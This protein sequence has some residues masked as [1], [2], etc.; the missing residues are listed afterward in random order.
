[1]RFSWALQVYGV[2][3]FVYIVTMATLAISKKIAAAGR[4]L[5]DKHGVEGVTMRRVAQAV[6]VTPMAIYRHYA[7]R[8]ALLTAVADE[9][10][11][12]LAARLARV[13]RTATVEKKLTRMGETFLDHALQNPRLFELM[14]LH[15]RV[16]ARRYPQDFKAGASPT[17]N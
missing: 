3:L 7:G 11:Q 15:P 1:M 4:R 8:A 6:G 2:Y 13:P 16:G 17:G 5:L 12:E 9:G 14:F 10:F